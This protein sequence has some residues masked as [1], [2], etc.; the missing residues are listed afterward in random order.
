MA[1]PMLFLFQFLLILCLLDRN[2]YVTLAHQLPLSLASNPI[3]TIKNT[4]TASS[5]TRTHSSS[6]ANPSA[7]GPHAMDEHNMKYWGAVLSDKVFSALSQQRRIYPRSNVDVS[8]ELPAPFNNNPNHN[9][10]Y[11][12]NYHDILSGV[13][14]I[15]DDFCFFKASNGSMIK[16]ASTGFSDECVLW[17]DACSGNRTA[18]LKKFFDIAF[19]RY[20]VPPLY[21]N[22]CFSQEFVNQSDCNT[23]N[24]PERLSEFRTIKDWMRSSQCVSA[25]DEWIAMTGYSWGYFFAGWNITKANFIDSVGNSS[26]PLPS[27]CGGC[28]VYAENVDLYY[29]PEPD[30]DQSCLSIVGDS[31]RPLD[32][33]ATTE[34]STTYW[35][36]NWTQSSTTGVLPTAQITTVGSL[37]VK[38]SSYNP[39]SSSPCVVNEP[40]SQ[41]QSLKARD[42]YASVYRRAHSLIIP[43]SI[44][45]ADGLPISTVIS[46]N[47]TL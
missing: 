21:N 8:T 15:D 9:P 32:Y 42:G 47:F 33:G 37:T 44:T 25:A 24:P 36:C 38:I 22:Q 1:E 10:L 13:C 39:W 7:S 3:T 2:N 41:N 40:G 31:V 34:G 28:L 35:A 29:W 26:F 17:D 19:T 4:S 14:T 27:C 11:L 5:L 16:A 45:Q 20:S 43:T 30:S 23:F 46:G 18:A 6:H 12:L